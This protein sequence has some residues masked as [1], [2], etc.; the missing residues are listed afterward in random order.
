MEANFVFAK[1]IEPSLVISPEQ[2][3]SPPKPAW[4]SWK[5]I[6]AGTI[7]G[8]LLGSA[9]GLSLAVMTGPSR[10]GQ[11]AEQFSQTAPQ[12]ALSVQTAATG[13]P[14]A[15][16]IGGAPVLPEA[17]PLPGATEQQPVSLSMKRAFPKRRTVAHK[18][19]VQPI[20]QSGQDSAE[21][22]PMPGLLAGPDE[23]SPPG[24][25]PAALDSAK[26]STFYVEGS[27]QV[28]DYDATAGTIET[29][30]GRTFLVG[31]TLSA[32]T[33]SSLEQPGS[34]HYR[35]GQDGSCVLNRAGMVLANV[36]QI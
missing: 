11:V 34:L 6:S 22:A 16:E 20:T 28:L 32:D 29:N 15:D 10:T 13:S 30:D 25:I 8:I 14:L 2:L 31:P 9:A 24:T 33:S 26:I 19:A 23:N 18:V 1:A 36:R 12:A 3:P 7:L 5:E 4:I 17:Q 35:C 27:I 21:V